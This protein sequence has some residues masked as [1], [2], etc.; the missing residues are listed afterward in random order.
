[1]KMAMNKAN[2][3]SILSQNIK[4]NAKL[5]TEQ[6]HICNAFCEYF[7]TVGPEFAQKIRKSKYG[8]KHY[9]TNRNMQL[10]Y[11]NP[12]DPDEIL[13]IINNLKPKSSSGPDNISSKLL[14]LLKHQV[15][16]PISIL[17]N[18]SITSGI[19][20][21]ILKVAKVVPMHKGK[22]KENN[23]GEN[24]TCTRHSFNH[25]LNME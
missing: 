9:M 11:M 12:T 19:F 3:K 7:T 15:N 21:E 17:I 22:S 1:M 14:K 5:L 4:Y 10:M 2:A 13:C 18:K 24:N 16:I 20:P 8:P 23:T 6:K 25:A